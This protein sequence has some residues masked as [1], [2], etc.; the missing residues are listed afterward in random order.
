MN[1]L[2]IL[3]FEYITGGGLNKSELPDSL[4]KEGLLMLRSLVNDLAK[5]E[6]VETTVMLYFRLE[7]MLYIYIPPQIYCWSGTG[8]LPR[9]C[10]LIADLRCRLADSAGK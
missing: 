7:E 5:I 10:P 6:N 1:T 3:V 8:L 4:A 9:I 2:K